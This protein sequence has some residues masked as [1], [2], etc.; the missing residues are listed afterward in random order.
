MDVQ[1]TLLRVCGLYII[2]VSMGTLPLAENTQAMDV[3]QIIFRAV[4]ITVT[5]RDVMN[6]PQMDVRMIQAYVAEETLHHVR[7]V[8]ERVEDMPHVLRQMRE[9]VSQYITFQ[10]A[11]D[12]SPIIFV[13]VII[14]RENV[15]EE[16]RAFVRVMPHVIVS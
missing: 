9:N 15:E 14:I 10:L 4:I 5:R 11:P 13:K 16:L 12:R 8:M 2:V 1:S 7:V 6:K 3:R